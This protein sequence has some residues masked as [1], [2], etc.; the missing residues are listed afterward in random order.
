MKKEK[1]KVFLIEDNRTEIMILKLALSG[2]PE[3][4]TEFFANG[5]DMLKS[6]QKTR[7]D[8]AIVDLLLPD[9]NGL[10]LI[11]KI[12]QQYPDLFII[13]VSAQDDMQVVVETQKEG[14]FNYIVKSES[15]LLYLRQTIGHALALLEHYAAVPK[16]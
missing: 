4:D 15:C 10:D 11:R 13:V 7:P 3:L 8:I 14:V 1:V 5:S 9:I 16:V 2:W 12:K 6:L